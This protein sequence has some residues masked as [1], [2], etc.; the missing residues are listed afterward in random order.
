[1]SSPVRKC[2]DCE[3]YREDLGWHTQEELIVLATW[4][5]G[6]E[7]CLGAMLGTVDDVH[8]SLIEIGDSNIADQIDYEHVGT[9][10]LSQEYL[11]LALVSKKIEDAQLYLAL[12]ELP[13]DQESVDVQ[14]VFGG[15]DHYRD[16]TVC[17]T[18]AAPVV[19]LWHFQKRPAEPTLNYVPEIG[20]V[21]RAYLT[22]Q[23][24]AADLGD[25]WRRIEWRTFTRSN[26]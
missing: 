5:G 22:R 26:Y 10:V 14:L 24:M 17:L 23:Q 8:P 2:C 16:K 25:L 7:I 13:A 20:S 3:R 19:P 11:T 1:M 6:A 12:Q 18:A 21:P 15:Y 9:L 4:E